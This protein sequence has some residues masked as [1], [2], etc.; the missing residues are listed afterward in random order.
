M[1]APK[2]V[3]IV[4][5]AVFIGSLCFWNCKP[6]KV[7]ISPEVAAS[8]EAL[9]KAGQG[10]LKKDPEKARLY[11]RQVIDTFPK[12]FYAQRAKLATADTYFQKGDEGSMILAASEYREFIS[13]YPYS[14]SASYAQYQIGMTSFKNALKAGRDQTKTIQSLAEFKR[15]ITNYPLSEEAKLAQQKISDCEERLAA[16]YF[17]IGLLY[18]KYDS[19][20]ASTSR[21]SEILTSYPNYTRMDEVYFYLADSYFKWG[22]KPESVPYFMKL[23]SDYPK[24]KFV[25]KAQERLAETEKTATK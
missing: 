9:F 7:E 5:L 16:H 3:I 12:S 11:F 20:K 25:K 23:V 24:S 8:D 13:L 17:T 22:K 19:F 2:K 15:V 21:L 10:Y 6:K 18:Y 14:P 4:V 1:N